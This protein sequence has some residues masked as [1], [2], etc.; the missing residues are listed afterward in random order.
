[1]TNLRFYRISI[2]PGLAVRKRSVA[3][4]LIASP[5]TETRPLVEARVYTLRLSE[6]FLIDCFI[7]ETCGS[8]SIA[9]LAVLHRNCDTRLLTNKQRSKD[10]IGNRSLSLSIM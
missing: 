8:F 3:P 2:K 10:F 7:L 4:G 1:M 6:I 9:I 5:I